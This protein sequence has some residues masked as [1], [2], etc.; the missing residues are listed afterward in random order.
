MSSFDAFQGQY[1]SLATQVSN[2][3]VFAAARELKGTGTATDA[4]FWMNKVT[5]NL[6]IVSS[7]FDMYNNCS[8]NYYLV[9]FGANLQSINGLSNFATNLAF[10]VFAGDDTTLTELEAGLV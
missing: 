10:R 4:G 8:L 9:G 3:D 2:I 7:A 6:Q 5:Q 1:S